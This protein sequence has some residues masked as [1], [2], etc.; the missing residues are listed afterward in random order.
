MH[1]VCS[2]MVQGAMPHKMCRPGELCGRLQPDISLANSAYGDAP[3]LNVA[4]HGGWVM[5]LL[6]AAG[7][8]AVRLA[9]DPVQG[10]GPPLGAQH[11][12]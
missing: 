11:C 6:A 12:M 10:L 9:D 7:G 2:F 8:P 3:L 4:V 5:P 1:T